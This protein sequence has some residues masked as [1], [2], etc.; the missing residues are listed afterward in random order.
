MKAAKVAAIIGAGPG[1]GFALA[2][3]FAHAGMSIALAARDASRLD[4]LASACCGIVHAARPYVCDATEEAAV[5][6]LFSLVEADLGAPQL[7]VYNAG[8]FVQRSV[9]DT[10]VEEFERCWRVGCLGG[11]LVGRAAARAML[12]HIEQGG[13]GGTILFTGATASLRG[14][15]GFHNL[16]VGKFGL[17]ALAQSMAR[18][19]GPRGI[20][21][22]HVVID[23]RIGPAGGEASASTLDPAA[24]AEA[25]YQLHCQPRSAWTQ[26][27][28]LRPWSEK[29]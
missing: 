27:L 7:V 4:G 12:S 11:F 18:E 8:A 22:A 23:G 14:S 6:G 24:I 13:E 10:S 1:L 9:L 17:R 15:A 26:E 29:F 28:D 25:Y 3:R 5:D 20:H 2:Q 16:A 19:L 21:V